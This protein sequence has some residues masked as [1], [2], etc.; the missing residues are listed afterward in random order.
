MEL[1][2]FYY[3]IKDYFLKQ[4]EIVGSFTFNNKNSEIYLTR[5]HDNVFFIKYNKRKYKL[6]LFDNKVYGKINNDLLK[7]LDDWLDSENIYFGKNWNWLIFAYK[8]CGR[9]KT[10]INTEMV[11][12]WKYYEYKRYIK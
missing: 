4:K 6:N 2:N 7:A 11:K 12:T 10:N 9:L 8:S 5:K 3:K 1:P